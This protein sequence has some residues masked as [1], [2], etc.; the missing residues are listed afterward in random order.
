MPFFNSLTYT[1]SRIGGQRER[2]TQAFE[3]ATLHFPRDYPFTRAYDEWSSNQE[4][5]DKER[6]Q[7]KPP[8]KRV[9]FEKLGTMHPWRADWHE[10]LGVAKKDVEPAF[11]PAQREME[12][13]DDTMGGRQEIVQPWLFRGSELSKIVSNLSSVF[14]HGAALL[15]EINRL[16]LKRKL[17]QLDNNIT[18]M[19]L[20][21]GALVNIKITM[22]IGGSLEDLA[23][24]YVLPDN[25]ALQWQ[26]VLYIRR[27]SRTSLEDDTPQETAVRFLLCLRLG[28]S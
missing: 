9:N 4:K 14:S 8:A 22:C 27:S 25:M 19:N 28:I 12:I 21:K 18:P 3:A 20:L 13:E 2:Q 7:R 23:M 24:I 10:L 6:W 5:E 26:K 1:G 15:S 16:R 11:I 17:D